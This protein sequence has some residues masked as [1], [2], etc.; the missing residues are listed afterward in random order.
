M[1]LFPHIQE[2]HRYFDIFASFAEALASTDRRAEDVRV[3]PIVVVPELELGNIKLHIFGDLHV[4][5]IATVLDNRLCLRYIRCES[6]L[7]LKG[8]PPGD[9]G[10]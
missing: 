1:L 9:T 7:A 8:Q 4:A 6:N 2:E 3:H 5:F 10:G